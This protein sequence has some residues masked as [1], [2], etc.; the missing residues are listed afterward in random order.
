MFLFVHILYQLIIMFV[1]QL[2]C[3]YIY[4]Y[5]YMFVYML[6][7]LE[8]CILSMPSKTKYEGLQNLRWCLANGSKRDSN[9]RGAGPGAQH[10]GDLT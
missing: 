6:N 7:L 4:L 10:D 3:I 5:N 1:Y 8:R 2:L 9:C